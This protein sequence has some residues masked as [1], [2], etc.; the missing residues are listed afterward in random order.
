MVFAGFC[1]TAAADP[2][3]VE[4]TVPVLPVA[5]VCSSVN[6]NAE[7]LH[8]ADVINLALCQNPQ[9]RQLYMSALAAAAEYGQ[10]KADYLPTAD[11]SAGIRQTDTR[12]HRGRDSNA[13]PVTAGISLDWL[14]YDFGGREASTEIVRQSLNAALATRSDT[15]QSLIFDAAEAY[16]LVLPPRKNIKIP[17][18][19]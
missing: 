6:V 17:M 7:K 2:F 5:P 11:L 3:D 12:V 18:R 8:L 13:T 19:R 16:Y 14:L 4:K 9:T 15:L 10:A 1:T